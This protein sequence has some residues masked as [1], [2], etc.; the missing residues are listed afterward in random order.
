M[1]KLFC[2]EEL[3]TF[4]ALSRSSG[5]Q[6]VLKAID[7]KACAPVLMLAFQRSHE[8][9]RSVD[10]PFVPRVSPIKKE[11]NVLFFESELCPGLPFGQGAVKGHNGRIR[12]LSELF[13][14]LQK[15]HS[16]GE[17]HGN[18]KP[19]NVLFDAGQAR[20]TLLDLG[21]WGYKVLR[22]DLAGQNSLFMPPEVSAT[23]LADVRSDFYG[24]GLLAFAL[25]TGLEVD[26]TSLNLLTASDRAAAKEWL[27]TQTTGLHPSAVEMIIEATSP[28]VS[29]RPQ[30]C[31]RLLQTL[32][33]ILDEKDSGSLSTTQKTSFALCA[34][35]SGRDEMIKRLHALKDETR[36]R[37]VGV[38]KLVG[39][40]GSGKSRIL[41][42]F[43]A[44]CHKSG[45]LVARSFCSEFTLNPYSSVT[46]LLESAARQV[47]KRRSKSLLATAAAVR[48][49]LARSLK[50]TSTPK[51]HLGRIVP[52]PALRKLRKSVVQK[53]L[54]LV[55]DEFWVFVLDDV[56]NVVAPVVSLLTDLKEGLE[57]RGSNKGQ[58]GG[59]FVLMS[60]GDTEN[61]ADLTEKQR[62]AR[63]PCVLAA[64]DELSA[65]TFT[66]TVRVDA[67]DEK[68]ARQ[69]V[70]SVVG[71]SAP[72]HGVASLLYDCL[73]GSPGWLAAAARLM[74][75]RGGLSTPVDQTAVEQLESMAARGDLATP[76]E[77][78]KALVADL[79]QPSEQLLDTIAAF[80]GGGIF[81]LI[82]SAFGGD[83]RRPIGHIDELCR[84]G[85]LVWRRSDS[86]VFVDFTHETLRKA[87]LGRLSEGEAVEIHKVAI[88]H[89][90]RLSSDDGSRY[91]VCLDFYLAKSRGG[92]ESFQ[93]IKSFSE[94]FQAAGCYFRAMELLKEATAMFNANAESLSAPARCKHGTELYCKRGD[95]N[96]LLA[97]YGSALRDYA[98]ALSFAEHGNRRSDQCVCLMRTAEVHQLKGELNKALELLNMAQ[99]MAV[100]NKDARFEARAAHAIGKACWHQGRLDDAL[101]SFRTALKHAERME[102]E[103][104]RA[105]L[106]H[107]TGAIFWA[108]GDYGRAMN[109][110]VQAR[111]I[112]EKAGEDRMRAIAINSI[113]SAYLEQSEMEPALEFFS[114]ALAVFRRLGDR[115]NISTTL[116]NV[117]I[118]SFSQG[119]IG[120]AL[121]KI[122]EVASMKSLIGDTRGLAA[123]LITKGEILR[124]IGNYDG[125]LRSHYEAYS[126]VAFENEPLISDT[127]LLE[128]GLDHLDAGTSATAKFALE[129]VLSRKQDVKLATTVLAMLG[130]AKFHL[131]L[132]EWQE[133]CSLCNEVLALLD[134]VKRPVD[135]ALCLITLSRSYLQLDRLDDAANCLQQASSI[136][137]KIN[138]PNLRFYLYWAL[139]D[140]HVKKGNI[141]ESLTSFSLAVTIA[142]SI[143]ATVPKSQQMWLSK[144]KDLKRFRES[145]DVVKQLPG[146]KEGQQEHPK[147]ISPQAATFWDSGTSVG[148]RTGENPELI[149]ASDVIISHLLNSTPFQRGCIAVRADSGRLQL[150]RAID[151]TGQVLDP[152][153]LDGPSY[154]SR[155]VNATG[156]AVFTRRGSEKPGWLN[157]LS[158]KGSII[159]V[160][161]SIGG[162]KLGTLY[163]DSPDLLEV[164][165]D[166]LFRDV[167]SVARL[168]A[169]M[170][171]DA[172]LRRRQ[173]SYI[174]DLIDRTRVLAV[175][176]TMPP[177]LV[178]KSGSLARKSPF[179]EIVGASQ[180]LADVMRDASK[181]AKTD[182]TVFI[183]GETGTG[184]ELLAQAIHNRSPRKNAPFV[185]INCG[186]IPRDLVE[187][188]LFGFEKGAFTGAHKQK[189]GRLEYG[190]KGTLF[191]DEIAELSLDMQVRF[192]RFLETKTVERVGG[193]GQTAIDCRIIAATNCDVDAAVKK[194]TFRE[195][196]YYR[197]STIDIKLPPIRDRDDDVLR[198]ANHFLGLCRVKYGKMNKIFSVKAIE[199]MMHYR[200]PGNVRELQNR[201]E[202]AVLIS[203]GRIITE[204]D[205]GLEEG[206]GGQIT[207]LKEV[208]NSVE[209]SRLKVALKASGG[210]VA[211]AAR[212]AGLSRQNFYRLTKKHNLSLDEFRSSEGS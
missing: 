122:E 200:W 111:E 99:S 33:P 43:A 197:L 179:P 23:R 107:N 143:A 114:E 64:F 210:N 187:A 151:K 102:D 86:S 189:R 119:N 18:L 71:S 84:R 206:G 132:A 121:E 195:D 142:E 52:S 9:M 120:F 6:V 79:N 190:D 201:V 128:I 30:S 76:S 66:E 203:T 80:P 31:D 59:L 82:S 154:V 110:F 87:C 176:H 98:E 135:K 212:I 25:L 182:V 53:I 91:C 186:A 148:P 41:D 183:T 46:Q 28:Q 175:E 117:A 48:S 36:K 37:G 40:P 4:A 94:A 83:N 127:V 27:E 137:E 194:G 58:K 192:L 149:E 78:A 70:Q 50:K 207:R 15:L 20:L 129:Q 100:S 1:L 103:A 156:K 77:V 199:R 16:I 153:R 38:V 204:G 92:P 49:Q 184:K 62:M 10:L 157:D 61:D 168:A 163:L 106:L 125:A 181:V 32:R 12:L 136:A 63:H 138:T 205:L 177:M 109:Y 133:A 146:P 101:R 17:F 170:I 73:G 22:D 67:L 147:D 144:N 2:R 130:L 208:K 44:Q 118:C 68:A 60:V 112:C 150:T 191:L 96:V 160:P 158:I 69:I 24:F 209:V 88:E 90:K 141:T 21:F 185:V 105:A 166:R 93:Y 124:A 126:F 202:K 51:D 13:L 152:K 11:G 115:R 81:E 5:R 57:Q 155:R 178:P 26:S 180:Q 7:E 42:E 108:K 19:N 131:G 89:W 65:H 161:L 39:P 193:E 134:K 145:W 3:G 198:L 85:L 139:G 164:S 116:Q 174:K 75:S 171:D 45:Q 172:V 123:A 167:Q 113:G 104:E 162:E 140:Y 14:A 35:F 159:C 95:L 34:E 55:K 97:D 47:D 29:R 8:L 196:L 165:G 169:R 56:Q 173:S 72:L 74:C 211:Q 54:D 188:E